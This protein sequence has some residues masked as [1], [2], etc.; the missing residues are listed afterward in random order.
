[1]VHFETAKDYCFKPT[2]P[3]RLDLSTD[4]RGAAFI[5]RGDLTPDPFDRFRNY[6]LAADCIGKA[7]L[8]R[9]T[10][11]GLVIAESLS[12]VATQNVIVSLHRSLE[13][14]KVPTNVTMTGEPMHDI[15][16]VL[17]KGFR[18]A[19]MHSGGAGDF[20]PFNVDDEETVRSALRLMRGVAWQY[21]K[22]H[23]R[24]RSGV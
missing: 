21:V 20:T 11:D 3:N 12:I 6:Y 19:L 5:R 22:Y 2:L 8:A 24:R 18:C 15:N 17:Y 4:W 7:A 10:K 13:N 1:M 23:E 9:P 16:A 14:L